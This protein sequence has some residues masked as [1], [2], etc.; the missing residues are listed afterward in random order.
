MA[1]SSLIK[2]F[3]IPDE[4]DQLDGVCI[5]DN[6]HATYFV[7]GAITKYAESR[8]TADKAC[9]VSNAEGLPT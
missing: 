5:S 8:S 4:A 6:M 9:R 3:W 2:N 7:L 1:F